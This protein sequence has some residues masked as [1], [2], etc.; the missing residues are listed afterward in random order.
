MNNKHGLS[1]T[2]LY[3]IYNNMITRCY[4]KTKHNYKNYGGK[5]I[6]VC[7]EW[8][9]NFLE[10]YYWAIGAG[11]SDELTLER[12]DNDVGYNNVNCKWIKSVEQYRNRSS[13]ILVEHNGKHQS[14]TDWSKELGVSYQS[15]RKKIK[16]GYSI[17]EILSVPKY[18]KVKYYVKKEKEI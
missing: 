3:R 2:R 11:Y 8:R 6:T 1:R 12:I 4:N 9:T 15:L 16:Q 14:I 17:E 18:G 13:T 10:F 5:G 7:D